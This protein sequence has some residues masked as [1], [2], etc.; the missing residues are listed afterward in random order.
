MIKSLKL[1]AK[2]NASNILMFNELKDLKIINILFGGN[3]VGKST[4]LKAIKNNE[5]TYKNKKNISI[6]YFQNS[7]SNLKINTQKEINKIT[8]L[9]KKSNTSTYS[10]GQSIMHYLLS[11]LQDIKEE[12]DKTEN[13][14]VVLLDEI[15][16]GLSAEN[17][18]AI[19]WQIK[20]LTDTNRVQF[21]I[22]SNHYHFIHVFKTVI[23]MYDGNFITIKS[24]EDFFERLNKGIQIMNKS[25]KRNFDF[26][27]I[28]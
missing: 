15:D 16:S 5:V 8:E 27:N 18:N 28:Y 9:I 22:S 6:F 25:G 21:F 14:I 4:L 12:V 13:S 1:K 3:G 19:L 20:D 11:F 23:N 17:I 26:L 10:E 7:E 24:Y 2:T